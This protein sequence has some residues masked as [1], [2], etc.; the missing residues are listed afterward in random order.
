M[1]KKTPGAEAICKARQKIKWEAFEEL[2][3]ESVEVAHDYFPDNSKYQWNNMNVYAVDGS[4]YQLPFTEELRS[5]FSP[6]CGFDKNANG[7]Y[8][9]GLVTTIFDVYREI[10]IARSIAPAATCERKEFMKLHDKVPSD[11]LL[12][13]DR[14]YPSYV[15]FWY[16]LAHI[17]ANKFLFRCPTNR[18]FSV[19]EKFI[20]SNK[21]DEIIELTLPAS[22][23]K[24]LEIFSTND[25]V[26]TTVKLRALKVKHEGKYRVY[27]TNLMDRE[28]YTL[29][30]IS[31][32]YNDRWA[33]ETYYRQEKESFKVEKFH[34]N[35]SNGIKQELYS[36]CIATLIARTIAAINTKENDIGIKTPQFKNSVLVIGANSSILSYDNELRDE[37][38]PWIVELIVG[39]TY[40]H[41]KRG[42]Q[43]VR[44][45]KQPHNKW[46]DNRRKKALVFEN[47]IDRA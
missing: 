44:I 40:I 21:S 42:R 19:L 3:Y 36:V 29:K 16:L 26:D 46:V 9:Q 45:S 47:N 20:K 5:E 37:Y 41:K 22:K 27:L 1:F 35:Q 33:V 38:I 10:P 31:N 8:P 13:F 7:H 34:S 11:S 2:F 28:K 17:N 15:M 30:S 4:K 14:G 12:V 6:N 32:M 23:S 43:Y 39:V 25:N 24:E 18:T